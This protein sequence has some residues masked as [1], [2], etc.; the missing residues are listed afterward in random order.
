SPGTV[1][2]DAMK[3]GD[4]SVY[5][6]AEIGTDA[7]GRPVY[8]GAIYDPVTTRNVTAGQVDRATGLTATS[9]AT[10]R[11]PFPG[12]IIPSNRFDRVAK[13][14]LPLFP[15][16]TRPGL[17][18]NFGSQAVNINQVDGWGTK[19]DHAL[20]N[21]HKLFGSFVWSDLNTPGISTYPG[22]LSSAIPSNNNI[23]IFRLGADSILHPNWINHVAF[24]FNR[25]RSGTYPTADALGWPAKI[26]LT[27]VNEEG[28]FPGFTIAGQ[29]YYGGTAI[30]YSAQSNFN[31]NDGLSWIKGKHNFKFGFEYLKMMS[32]DANNSAS[33]GSDTGSF[34]FNNFETALPSAPPSVTGAGMASFLLGQVDSGSVFVFTS[35]SYER[36]GYYAGYAQD[37]FR[38]TPKL[39]LN[40]GLRYDLYRPTVDKWN[41]L[42]WVDRTL[43]NPALG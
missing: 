41:H 28:V 8:Q 15:E 29:D 10:I 35:S 37:D 30:G 26:G 43:P 9:D 24:G 32:N 7:L 1:P 16:P 11:D 17:I 12:N 2:T 33:T 21:N 22:V 27:G 25:W 38:V 3:Q 20:N 6:G 23:R 4:L 14:I 19:I 36:S 34:G 5:L 18:Y 13:N 42:A 31:I 40:L 39:T